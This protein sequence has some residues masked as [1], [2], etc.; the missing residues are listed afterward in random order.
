MSMCHCF[1]VFGKA[2]S[3]K[4]A[5]NFNQSLL[6]EASSS[7]RA[8][9]GQAVAH[10]STSRFLPNAKSEVLLGSGTLFNCKRFDFSQRPMNIIFLVAIG[11]VGVQPTALGLNGNSLNHLKTVLAGNSNSLLCE[12]RLNEG[13]ADRCVAGKARAAD[14]N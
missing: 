1:G 2:V 8:W 13:C 6:A 5:I 9:D 7:R 12:T 11:A 14:I 3:S 10:E 4:L